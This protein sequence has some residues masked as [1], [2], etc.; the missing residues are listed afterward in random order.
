M[1]EYV[2]GRR[3]NQQFGVSG[4]TTNDTVINVI[5]RVAVGIDN[6]GIGTTSATASIDT[7]T[8][9][10]RDTVIDSTGYPGALGYFLTKDVNGI[11]WTAVPP[12]N[13][14]AIFVA[15]D[16]DIIGVSSF[17]GLNFVANDNYYNISTNTVNTNF[18]DINVD[19]RWYRDR[20]GSGGIYT[21]TTVG[22][23]STIPRTSSG[24][25]TDIKL[26]I[27]GDASISGILSVGQLIGNINV[28]TEDLY[29]NGLSTF[30]GLS[31][32]STV[33][34]GTTNIVDNDVLTIVGD[35]GL[36]GETDTFK[37]GSAITMSNGIV[38][39]TTFDGKFLDVDYL[40][41]T[42]VATINSGIITDLYV[43]GL[44]TF[45]GS[46][47]ILDDLF[48]AGNVSVAG[49]SVILDAERLRIEDKDIVLG[50]TTTI[51]PNDT[52][53][54]FGGIAVA[55]TDGS[56]LADLYVSGVNTLPNTYKQIKWVK[57]GSFSGMTT[58]AWISNYAIS[59]G[60]TSIKDSIRLAVGS[61]ITMSDTE[62]SADIFYGKFLNLEEITTQRLNVTGI[63]T[64]GFATAS[65]LY[66]SGITTSDGGFIG[67]LTGTASTAS[68]AT[69]A[70]TLN[71]RVESEFNVAT[72]VTST[73]VIGGIASVTQL[74]VSGVST[75]GFAT[76]SNLYVSGI[77]TSD[78]GFIGNLTGTASTASFATTAFSLNGISEGGLNVAFAQTS[79]IATNLKGGVAGNV[80]YQSAPDTTTFVTNGSPGQVLL[81]NGSIPIWSNVSAATG[82]FGGITVYDEGLPVGTA[83][84]ITGLNIVGPNVS[85]TATTG[86]NGIATISVADYV[87]YASTAG[88]ATYATS[89]GISTYSNTSGV[90]TSVIGGIASVTQ[91]SVSG[92]STL[93]VV[94]AA[95]IFSTGI[96]TAL[97]FVGNLTGTASTA[98]FA[99]TAFSLNGVAEGNLS[100]GF[101]RTAGI[102]TFAT[103]AGIATNLKGGVAGN[104]PYQSATDTT[105][106]VTNGSS[107][108][109]LLFNGSIPIWGN[110]SA[111][112]GAFGGITVYDE[113]N[114]VGTA[115]SIASLDFVGSNLTVTGTSGA[116]GIATVTMSDNLVGTA[117]SISGISTFSNNVT[118]G[119][120]ITM[121]ASTGIVSATAFYGS[122]LNLSDLILGKIEGLQIQEEGSDIGVGFTYA[123]LNFVGDYVTATGVGTVA[124]ITFTTPPYADVAGIATYAT[125]AGVATALQNSR[126]FSVSGDV[127]TSSAVT[128]DGTG[129][130]D[131]AVTLSNTFSANTSGI[132]TSSGGFVGNLTGTATTATNLADAANITTG[133][134]DSARLT[135]TYNID[136]SGNAATADYA[137]VAGIATYASN[138]GVATYSGVSGFS[139]FS[140]YATTAGVA[141]Y[142]GVSGFSTFS[143]YANVA[144]I[145][146]YA[147]NAGVA[148]YANLAGVS[149]NVIGGIASVTQLS[150]S[151]ISTLGTVEIS[152]GI[153]TA[154]SGIVTYYGD[155]SQLSG[156]QGG[157]GISTNTSN[158]AQYIPYATS[159]GSTTGAG[160][161][162][163]FVYNPSTNR[164]GIGT[165]NPQANLHVVD[166]FLVSTAGAASTQRISQKAYTL[167]NGSLS[168]EGSAGQLFSITNNL[169]SGS[170]FS[171]N[172][173]S[174]IP[175]ID[176]DA[177][178][179]IQLA[180]FG[181][182]EYVGVGTTNPQAKL[183][184]NGGLIVSGVST[185]GTV[186]ISSG[187]VTASSGIVT[188][189]GDG[190]NLTNVVAASSNGEFYTG[191]SSSIQLTPLSY[192]TS[193]YTFPSTAGK[194]YVIESINV[195]NVDTSVGVGTTVNIIASI[196][197]STGEQ[198]YIAYN[199]PIVNGGLI[200][201]LKNAIVA[202]PSDVIKMWTTNDAYVGVNTA[203]EVYMNYTEFTSTEYISEYA[204]TVSIA[205]T[206]PTA[207]YTSS[208]YPSTIESIHFANRTDSGDYPVSVSI[209][210]GLTT[211][212]LAK[213]LIIPRYSTVDILDRP[214]RIETNGV[215]KVEVGQTSTI[216]VIIAGK[217]ITS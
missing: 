186:Q 209:T 11:T 142:S 152:S 13:N 216:D 207:V 80:P 29:V 73:N 214:K 106:F 34:I 53:G 61:A 107:G 37:V 195:A 63:S 56:P 117:L 180:P 135:G 104:V 163:L 140:G 75:L 81:F 166:E 171:V 42:G 60:N 190:S 121:Y 206:D 178:G 196:Q 122:G 59:I 158:Q 26:D 45:G 155:G 138:A 31:T 57:S 139:T 17:T 116:N 164:L 55:S 94:T 170:I 161:T 47:N 188:Y 28:V 14:N 70:F 119:S 99:T 67:N 22:I 50:F 105:T 89:A 203:A 46:V 183:D 83:N 4:I 217:Q 1:A 201:L 25:L 176:V 141:T 154:S 146:T 87:S 43:T 9:R 151:G 215:I 69:T 97:T 169:T 191:V 52:T 144:G 41:V 185:L 68:F 24:I 211:T 182:S 147:S 58:D 160:A 33:G 7:D 115:G 162:T 153:V 103:N 65:N 79:G 168:W 199:V 165:T 187:I 125:T 132:I 111:A 64:L 193:I 54:N 91:L 66:V 157:L 82:A 74:S 177:D 174:G 23:G 148:T 143:G 72:A 172:D 109:V 71:N 205:T 173:V 96:V 123:T 19:L 130:V 213:N 202:G 126:D 197:D 90:S 5:G 133:T 6:L 137:D 35:A 212:Y 179:T 181:A 62:I 76:A 112:A 184:V 134:I 167:N 208:T 51:Q 127:A 210:N 36:R 84:S 101:A 150:V 2:S 204:S 21:T 159:F 156:I 40:T 10:I 129:N 27:I 92:V 12:L 16:G 120:G 145:A 20:I 98:S 110:V 114:L 78:G 48:V 86:P 128:F 39:A 102:A 38:T 118:V 3:I 8:L 149:T 108:Q 175:S 95:N 44:S 192:E 49:S 77:T 194:Q 88:I 85:A 30:I 18:A 136:I 113:G 100:V 32:F 93:G 15:S 124:N 198:T 189:Y 131:L 200:E